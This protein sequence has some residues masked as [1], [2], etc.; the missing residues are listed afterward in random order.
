MGIN[1]TR[2]APTSIEALSDALELTWSDGART[3]FSYVRLRRSC[4]CASC[5]EELTG[6]PVLDPE[7]IPPDIA[8]TDI[9]AVGNYAVAIVWSDGHSSGIY[10]WDHFRSLDSDR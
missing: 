5:V 1:D 8:P 2:P 10:S 7:S 3:S 4:R 9:R 6:R